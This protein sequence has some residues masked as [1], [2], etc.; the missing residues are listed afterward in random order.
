[1]TGPDLSFDR[2][3]VGRRFPTGSFEVTEEAVAGYCESVGEAWP[4]AGRATGGVETHR[5]V[6]PTFVLLQALRG[7]SDL[8]RALGLP[9]RFGDLSTQ[10]G[11]AVEVLGPVYLGDRI[12]KRSGIQDAYRKTGR[13]GLLAFVV[14]EAE[15]ANQDGTVV[16][17]ARM[18]FMTRP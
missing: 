8:A 2:R 10:T 9:E 4:G 6:P 11:E 12:E 15:F 13:T 14:W 16:A 7:I 18:S 17:R 3:L 1:M 5:P